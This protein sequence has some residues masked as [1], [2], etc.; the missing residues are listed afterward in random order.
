MAID[1]RGQKLFVAELENNSLDIVNLS[2]ARRNYRFFKTALAKPQGVIFIPQPNRIFV[3]NSQDGSV[4]I[5]DVI[6]F[7]F[8]KKQSFLLVMQ[9]ICVMTVVTNS[10]IQATDKDHL[11]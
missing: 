2:T 4:D 6:S 10:S 9:I 11:V 8:I 1:I 7:S 3:S 5:F